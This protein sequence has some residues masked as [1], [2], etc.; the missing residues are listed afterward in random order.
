MTRSAPWGDSRARWF[1]P[2]E[3]ES[4]SGPA[5]QPSRWD[6]EAFAASAGP[7]RASCDTVGECDGPEK[8]LTAVPV[9]ILL[10][11]LWGYRTRT[12]RR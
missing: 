7:C 5:F 6:P 11:A 9:L 8:A 12:R 1:V 4:P 10:A 3:Q 2:P